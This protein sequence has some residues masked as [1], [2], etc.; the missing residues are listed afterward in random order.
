MANT[1]IAERLIGYFVGGIRSF[2]LKQTLESA[3]D[4]ITDKAE[5][6]LYINF[7]HR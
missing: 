4:N 7:E 2:G 6:K 1:T 3:M 5:M